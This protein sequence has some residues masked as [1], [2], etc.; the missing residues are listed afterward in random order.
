M[1]RTSIAFC[2]R[3][4]RFFFRSAPPQTRFGVTLRPP[5]EGARFAALVFTTPTRNPFMSKPMQILLRHAAKEPPPPG[6]PGIFALGA[7]KLLEKK[8]VESGYSN[9]EAKVLP[10]RLRRNS[11]NEALHDEG[12]IRCVPSCSGRIER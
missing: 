12:R 7:P 8:L 4:E 9:V 1:V 11:A 3:A 5:N 10:V 6:G 2:E